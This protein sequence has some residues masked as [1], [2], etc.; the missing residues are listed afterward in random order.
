[1][2]CFAPGAQL[3]DTEE[4]GLSALQLELALLPQLPAN[5][6]GDKARAPNF[7]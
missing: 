3:E 6:I 7:S 5:A 1:M 4:V 2:I